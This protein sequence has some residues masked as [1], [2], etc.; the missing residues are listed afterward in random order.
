[1][2]IPDVTPTVQ[3]LLLLRSVPI[4]G[5]LAPAELD[6]IA[7]RCEE[8]VFHDGD[9]LAEQGSAGEELHIIVMGNVDVLVEPGRRIATRGTGEVIGEMSLISRQ[10]RI[11]TLKASGDVRARSPC[12]ARISR[13]SCAN[14]HRSRCR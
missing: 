1:M 3:R 9:V 4:F 6:A 12:H 5:A 8:H 10:P 11:A 2:A 7:L 13:R 14:G